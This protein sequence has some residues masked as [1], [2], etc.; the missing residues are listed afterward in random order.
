MFKEL[1]REFEE[2]CDRLIMISVLLFEFGCLVFLCKYP[3]IAYVA[4]QK[5]WGLLTVPVIL[6]VVA[7]GVVGYFNTD[8]NT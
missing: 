1:L 2:E 6:P 7:L 3:E 8:S 4:F 5:S